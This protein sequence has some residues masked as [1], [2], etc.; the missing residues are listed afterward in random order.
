MNKKYIILLLLVCCVLGGGLFAVRGSLDRTAPEIKLPEGQAAYHREDTEEILLQG[1]T[2]VDNEDGDVTDSL[3]VENIFTDDANRVASV[4]YVAKDSNNNVTKATRQMTWDPEQAETEAES[5]TESETEPETQTQPVTETESETESESDEVTE[6]ESES[7]T[8]QD[9]SVMANETQ[10]EE[11]S[12]TEAVTEESET[13]TET[14]LQTAAL[15]PEEIADLDAYYEEVFAQLPAEC[16]RLRLTNRKIE[17]SMGDTFDPLIY[18]QSIEDDVDNKY[19][20]WRQIS[21]EG[22]VNTQ[23]PG[24]YQLIYTASD[25]SGNVSNRAMLLVDVQGEYGDETEEESDR[26]VTRSAE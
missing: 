7:E 13:T 14:E 19:E 25:N 15:D 6:S 3:K 10:T 26:E 17:I 2:A 16:P 12:G 23:I 11:Q 21:V 22:E 5:E 1:V 4:V 20:L 18:V 9:V 24:I 8:V